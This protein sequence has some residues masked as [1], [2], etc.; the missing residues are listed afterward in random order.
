MCSRRGPLLRVSYP[1]VRFDSSTKSVCL[2][3]AI[4]FDNRSPNL[5]VSHA[6]AYAPPSSQPMC[7]KGLKHAKQFVSHA[8]V[9]HEKSTL[10]SRS[11]PIIDKWR[12]WN[13]IGE[14]PRRNSS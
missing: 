1:L 12:Q 3:P 5:S 2:W 10:Q 4:T 7:Y 13:G 8:T 6:R 14:E 11:S 9:R